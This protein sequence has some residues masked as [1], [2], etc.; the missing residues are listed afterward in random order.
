M[1]TGRSCPHPPGDHVTLSG[2]AVRGLL[3]AGQ[4]P[5]REFSRPEVASVLAAGYRDKGA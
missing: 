2:T 1:A 3:S 4:L 5:P